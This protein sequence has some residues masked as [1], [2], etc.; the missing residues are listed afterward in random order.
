[1]AFLGGIDHTAIADDILLDRGL[2]IAGRDESSAGPAN[3]ARAH[4]SSCPVPGAPLASGVIPVGFYAWLS[5]AGLIL[6]GSM[7]IWW[8]TEK[9]WGKFS[10]HDNSF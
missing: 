1:V 6:G 3:A 2:R 9:A 4:S 10:R 7:I 8:A 5:L